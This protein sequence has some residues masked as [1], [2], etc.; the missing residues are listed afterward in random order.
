M[1]LWAICTHT[2]HYWSNQSEQLCR[3]IIIFTQWLTGAA[4]V[5]KIMKQNPTQQCLSFSLEINFYRHY[6]HQTHH[7]TPPYSIHYAK[8]IKRL[9]TKLK[10]IAGP[11]L[12]KK[13]MNGWKMPAYPT[14]IS[15]LDQMWDHFCFDYWSCLVWLWVWWVMTVTASH[16]VVTLSCHHTDQCSQ[17]GEDII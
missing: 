6:R 1:S 14:L 15:L 7:H 12:M 4:I 3:V 16:T 5:C 11:L 17:L 13:L 2:N 10:C 8:L 9:S